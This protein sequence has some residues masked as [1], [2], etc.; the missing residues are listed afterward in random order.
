MNKRAAAGSDTSDT[1]DR[2]EPLVGSAVVLRIFE[3]A[4]GTRPLLCCIAIFLTTFLPLKGV[5]YWYCLLLTAMC[6]P[7]TESVKIWEW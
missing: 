3:D 7:H 5:T 6:V 4:K 1:N 2:T